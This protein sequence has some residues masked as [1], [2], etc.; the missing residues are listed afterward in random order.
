[1]SRLQS[2]LV[3]L[4]A[5]TRLIAGQA[6]ASLDTCGV[7]PL[8]FLTRSTIR[9]FGARTFAPNQFPPR[10]AKLRQQHGPERRHTWLPNRIQLV[11]LHE[12]RLPGRSKR[13]RHPGLRCGDGLLCR[14]LW[15][16][17]LRK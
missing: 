8:F 14:G 9:V 13:L 2:A 5:G 10:V 3:L 4:L 15:F 7:S 12:S 6:F 17:S 1:M 11:S 16:G